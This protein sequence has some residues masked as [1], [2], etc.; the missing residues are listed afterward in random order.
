[1]DEFPLDVRFELDGWALFWADLEVIA[2]SGEG[3][4]ALRRSVAEKPG[5]LDSGE[6]L[7]ESG[8]EG[9]AAP[10]RTRRRRFLRS[11][12]AGSKIRLPA[13]GGKG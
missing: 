1:M 3:L 10:P 6:P 2:E 13:F 5:A 4:A 11:V 7:G 12:E 9:D 8:G